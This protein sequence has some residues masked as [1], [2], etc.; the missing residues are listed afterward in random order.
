M[1]E[2]LEELERLP[3]PAGVDTAPQVF[4]DLLDFGEFK[5]VELAE[6]F[7]LDLAE[8]TFTL[9]FDEASFPP[10]PEG[11]TEEEFALCLQGLL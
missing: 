10:D 9:L 8:D 2:L 5:P 4:E 3:E 7:D 1:R 11:P 6:D